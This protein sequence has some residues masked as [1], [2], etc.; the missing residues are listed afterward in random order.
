M[1]VKR[2]FEVPKI[3]SKKKMEFHKFIGAKWQ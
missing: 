1:G 2:Y 3:I